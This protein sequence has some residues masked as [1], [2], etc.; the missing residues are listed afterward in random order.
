[1]ALAL[2]VW[3]TDFRLLLRIVIG[4]INDKDDKD[5]DDDGKDFFCRRYLS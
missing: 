5:D 3:P 1:M 4:M 2:T